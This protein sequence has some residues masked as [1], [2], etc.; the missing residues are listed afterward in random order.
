MP[1]TFSLVLDTLF[2]LVEVPNLTASS[3]LIKK[4]EG[5]NQVKK[6]NLVMASMSTR[7]RLLTCNLPKLS[8]LV[9]IASIE[10]H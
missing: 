4:E 7:G 9:L 10:F 2:D 3:M 1:T 6:M 5:K 8:F